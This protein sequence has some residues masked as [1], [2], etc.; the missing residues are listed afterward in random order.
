MNQLR[1]LA[2]VLSN[3]P[4]GDVFVSMFVQ[5]KAISSSQIEETQTIHEI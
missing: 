5:K 1:K 2:G 3:L 4:N